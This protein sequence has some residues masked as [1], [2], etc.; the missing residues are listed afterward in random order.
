[1]PLVDLLRGVLLYLLKEYVRGQQVSSSQGVAREGREGGPLD[2]QSRFLWTLLSEVLL[3]FNSMGKP[4]SIHLHWYVCWPPLSHAA[5][6][7]VR[8]P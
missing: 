6:A 5:G 2:E 8:H 3:T 7:R 4:L 1:V